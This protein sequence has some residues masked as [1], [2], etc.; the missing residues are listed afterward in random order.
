MEIL[1]GTHE[2]QD[3]RFGIVVSKFNEFI[4]TRLLDSA[5]ETFKKGGATDQHIRIV[6]VPG[7][8]EIPLVAR[9]LAETHQFDAII[10][11]G[12]V[13]RGETAHFDYICAETSRGIA[14]AALDTGV[15][16]IFGVL[17]TETVDQALERS[18][19]PQLNRG[20]HA[21]QA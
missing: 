7:A 6:K 20:I 21:A 14:R 4:T 16:I 15:P 9:Q 8:F 11:L 19:S 18:E 13:I 3:S 12:S 10:C 5:L 1:E 17:T 2:V